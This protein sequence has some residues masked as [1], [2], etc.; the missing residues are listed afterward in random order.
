MFPLAG[1]L[2]QNQILIPPGSFRCSRRTPSPAEHPQGRLADW[3]RVRGLLG[4]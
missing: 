3:L 4:R 2:L 1:N